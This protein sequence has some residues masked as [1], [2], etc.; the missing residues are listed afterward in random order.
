MKKITLFALFFAFSMGANAAPTLTWAPVAGINASGVPSLGMQYSN[1]GDSILAGSDSGTFG[2]FRHFWRFSSD[3]A[4]TLDSLAFTSTS[5]LFNS[6][7]ISVA[8]T[9]VD[10]WSPEALE[11]TSRT[12]GS[13]PIPLFGGAVNFVQTTLMSSIDILAGNYALIVRGDA[14]ALIS[15]YNF[16][17]AASDSVNNVT[18]TPLPAAAWLFISAILGVGG[19]SSRRKTLP[20]DGLAG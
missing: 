10:D 1:I 13:V 16:T 20:V 15:S 5:S 2:G 7:G 11:E 19:L 12:E 14:T 18:S 6:A 8:L 17:L 3:S 4:G 9:R